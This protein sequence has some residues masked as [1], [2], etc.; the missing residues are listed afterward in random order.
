MAQLQRDA[1]Q[2]MD[3]GTPQTHPPEGMYRERRITYLEK[4]IAE[5]E[6]KL[7]AVMDIYNDST[8]QGGWTLEY[9]QRRLDAVFRQETT[10]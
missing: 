10:P 7:V 5:L 2:K 9:M 4:R 8:T 3:K 6:G 1:L